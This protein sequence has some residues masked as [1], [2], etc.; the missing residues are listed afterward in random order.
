MTEAQVGPILV[1]LATLLAAAHLFGF[2][3]V[4]LRQP[5]F[6]GEIVA[7]VFVGPYVLGRPLPHTTEALLGGSGSQTALVLGF[8]SWL[9]L[10]LLMFVTGAEVRRVLAREQWAP[11]AWILAVGTAIPFVL[12]FVVAIVLPLSSL[13]GPNGGE[14]AFAVTL[15]AATAITSVPVI[16]RIFH[17]LKILHTRFASLVL[18][19]AMMED[20]GL[21][22]ALAVATALAHY[23]PGEPLGK[24]LVVRIGTTIAF[25]AFG[26]LLAPRILRWVGTLRANVLARRERVAYALLLML[27]YTAAAV[28]LDVNIF[29]GAFLAGFGLVGGFSG[30]ERERFA[31]ALDAI[32]RVG[33]A[34]FIPLYFVLVGTKLDLGAGF[35]LSVL[36]VFLVGSSV[37]RITFV[38][39]AGGFARFSR[40]DATDLAVAM[41]ARG[42]PGIVLATIVYE[43]GI[44][45]PSLFTALVVTAVVTSQVAGWWLDRAIRRRGELLGEAV[46]KNDPT[47][48]AGARTH[49]AT[50]A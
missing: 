5:R 6:V 8:V 42:G 37:L 13:W 21:F 34:T 10:L 41:N 36:L 35:S 28:L 43:A 11:T 16:S 38:G 24:D 9:G 20:I 33:F 45:S 40:R 47:G 49:P 39:M 27:V 30:S 7:G 44:I 15:A 22:A 18:G 48:A 46:G 19:T 26:L 50:G 3:A 12:A 23:R 4:R 31:P 32:S 14:G 2:V 1:S 29:F 17:D 25:L